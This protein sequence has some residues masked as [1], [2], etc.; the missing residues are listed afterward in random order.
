MGD[1][2]DCLVIETECPPTGGCD[3]TATLAVS[4]CAVL[5]WES[6]T[7]RY[8]KYKSLLDGVN[9]QLLEVAPETG[10]SFK[11]HW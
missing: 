6:V 1:V 7:L 9:V 2:G 5:P 10:L 3:I 11:Y 8:T 4:D